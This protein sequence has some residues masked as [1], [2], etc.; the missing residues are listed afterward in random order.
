MAELRLK[1]NQWLLC[2]ARSTLKFQ[3]LFFR[4]KVRLNFQET[5]CYQVAVRVWHSEL[6][7]GLK[8]AHG[9]HMLRASLEH[10]VINILKSFLCKQHINF[11]FA[12]AITLQFVCHSGMSIVLISFWEKKLSRLSIASYSIRASMAQFMLIIFKRK[13][14]ERI[15]EKNQ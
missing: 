10:Q 11:L 6:S 7:T 5:D 1:K 15:F 8:I 4:L 2:S 3:R 13:N 12:V 9:E 14:M